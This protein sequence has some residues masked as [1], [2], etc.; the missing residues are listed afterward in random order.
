MSDEHFQF[1]SQAALICSKNFIVP[2]TLHLSGTVVSRARGW[3]DYQPVHSAYTANFQYIGSRRFLIGLGV[4]LR[5]PQC[6]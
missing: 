4:T 3:S 2:G 6:R 5:T 1:P